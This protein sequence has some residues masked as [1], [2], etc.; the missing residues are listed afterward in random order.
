MRALASI[1]PPAANGTISVIGRLG[2]SCA[3]AAL[4]VKAA[5]KAATANGVVNRFIAFS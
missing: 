2:Q 4:A 5:S 1:P 3:T